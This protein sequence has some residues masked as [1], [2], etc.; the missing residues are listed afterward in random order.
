MDRFFVL[1]H[2]EG[3]SLANAV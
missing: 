3:V 1:D 2:W